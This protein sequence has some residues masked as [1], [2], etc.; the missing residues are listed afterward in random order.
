MNAP[1]YNAEI[2]RLA[3]S[4]AGQARLAD[5]HV[6]V[7]KRSPTCGS[8][9]TV[10]L[11]LEG[12]RVAAFGQEVRACALGQ[13]GAALLGQY[14]IG[15]DANAIASAASDLRAYLEGTR[16]DPGSWPGLEIFAP[17]RP[18]RARH[19]SILLAFDAAAEAIVSRRTA[20]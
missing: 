6:T 8:R 1:L 14:V 12:D 4:L 5:P 9:V 10:D 20:A 3:A 13:A 15:S 17:A 16:A 19:A 11:V 18:H 7:E 2:L